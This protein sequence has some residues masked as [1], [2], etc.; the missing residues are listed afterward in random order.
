M[1]FLNHAQ[2]EFNYD[3]YIYDENKIVAIGEDAF[4][5]AYVSYNGSAVKKKPCIL[6]I[7][8]YKDNHTLYSSREYTDELGY[9]HTKIK[10][11]DT[12]LYTNNYTYTLQCS[13]TT[14]AGSIYVKIGETP[15]WF[16]NPFV[17]VNEN[18]Q[19][20]MI[21]LMVVL[22]FIFLASVIRKVVSYD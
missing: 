10:I 7:F 16:L 12:F 13:N 15:N 6:S 18:S 11:T 17:Y 9:I 19:W 5:N 22:C 4:L 3:V 20:L 2:G 8:D 14:V 1:A 21:F